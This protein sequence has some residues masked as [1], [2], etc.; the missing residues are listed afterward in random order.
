MAIVRWNPWNLEHFFDD[1]FDLPTIPGLSRVIGQG[2]NL[3]ETEE[4]IIA[5]AS[6]P[7]IKEDQIDVTTDDGIVR[8]SASSSD[9]TEDKNNRRYFMSSRATSFNYSFRLPNGLIE[10]SEPVCELA[11]GVLTLKFKKLKKAPPKKLKVIN[12]E[13]ISQ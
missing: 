12:K 7:G 3:Y 4:E 9:Q 8:I 5:E 6:L 2:L 11:A 10:D 13:V 1:D